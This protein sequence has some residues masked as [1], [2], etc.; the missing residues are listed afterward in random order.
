[1]KI[2][3][4][5]N[6]CG[7][8]QIYTYTISKSAIDIS[9]LYYT[10]FKVT[11]QNYGICIK[12]IK[13]KRC[14]LIQPKYELDFKHV[15]EL[16]SNVQDDK[17][18][19]SS[20]IRGFSS[21]NQIIPLI[22][23]YSK[24]NESL[25]EIGAGS[26]SLLNLF[27]NDFKNVIGIEPNSNFCKFAKKKYDLKI[28]NIGYELIDKK[29]KYN[30]II[31]LNI[32]EH[33]VSVDNFM[34]TIKDSLHND[35]IAI[36]RTPNIESITAKLLG[37]RWWHVRPTHL[38]YFCDSSFK[39]LSDKYDL[40]ITDRRYSSWNLPLRYILD[41]IQKLILRKS[42]LKLDNINLLVKINTFDSRLYVLC[43][44]E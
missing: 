7:S 37:K 16:Y 11:D 36:I 27:R 3:K 4:K 32:I 24:S 30:V 6:V 33:V 20:E 23:K 41:S 39:Y 44:K 42:L 25:L 19:E 8:E 31:A 14:E 2:A 12:T 5:C 17:Y 13:C 40:E 38:Y 34:N 1:M 10:S 15:I 9:E 29:N 28:E 21:Y 35:G 26:G 18:F 43:N 22:N